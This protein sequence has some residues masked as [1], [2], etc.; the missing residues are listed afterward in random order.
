M[1]VGAA[2]I[3]LGLILGIITSL[4]LGHKRESVA[5]LSK[6]FI[7]AVVIL[8]LG[9]YTKV[10]P[11]LLYTPSVIALAIAFPVLVISGGLLAPLELF[12]GLR[13]YPFICQTHG[14]WTCINIPCICC[15]R[16]ERHNRQYNTRYLYR[17]FISSL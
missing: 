8:L 6:L 3:F 11:Q 7:V 10:V 14:L 16:I 2:H 17:S 1:S 15:K 9:V 4:R 12:K 13:Q 5:K